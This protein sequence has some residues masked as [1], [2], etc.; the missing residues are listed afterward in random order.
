LNYFTC[1]YYWLIEPIREKF[2][3]TSEAKPVFDI[4]I[5][6]D[7]GMNR[8]S[9]F[10]SDNGVPEYGR[11]I[12]PGLEEE[13]IS[14]KFL[15]MI[16][17]VKEH[18]LSILRITYYSDATLF[19][20][21]IWAFVE[22]TSSY[23]IGL[24]IQKLANL[25]FDIEKTKRLFIGGFPYREELR[26]FIDGNDERI[27]IQYRYLSL[28]KIIELQYRKQ[29]QW[30]EEGLE[31][32]LRKY[33]SLF[34]DIGI[35]RKPI[36]HIHMLRDK[37]AHIKTGKTDE[38]YG[39]TQLNHKEAAEVSQILSIMSNICIEILNERANGSFTIGEKSF[40]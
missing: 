34:A 23:S 33:T 28:Y 38:A 24:E 10:V 30:H 19:P 11:L 15:P 7:W 3:D 36:S 40:E 12:I 1:L 9:L 26:L 16:Q 21:P 2:L 20:R 18:F 25:N 6:S 29:R 5:E 4:P 39:V 27:P 8:F 13:E 32:L 17:A 37:C 31:L 14:E 35:T 22:D